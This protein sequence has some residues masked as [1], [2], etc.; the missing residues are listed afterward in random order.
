[1]LEAEFRTLGGT[2]DNELAALKAARQREPCLQRR[3]EQIAPPDS[4][5]TTTS[6]SSSALL[7]DLRRFDMMM[8]APRAAKR[9]SPAMPAVAVRA[10]AELYSARL[11]DVIS[12]HG[13]AEDFSDLDFAWIGGARIKAA[14]RR[15]IDL[16]GE[17]RG[18]RVYLEVS[19]ARAEGHGPTR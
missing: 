3:H 7:L 4:V 2:V 1:M 5:I 16:A 9:R 11:G 12:I 10:G 19:R 15:W 17:F 6:S 13:A 8:R 18:R 14:R